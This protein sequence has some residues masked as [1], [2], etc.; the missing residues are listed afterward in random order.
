VQVQRN[1]EKLQ[2]IAAEQVSSLRVCAAETGLRLAFRHED[3]DSEP[4]K[5]LKAFAPISAAIHR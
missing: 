3:H 4:S 1:P 2:R 5:K